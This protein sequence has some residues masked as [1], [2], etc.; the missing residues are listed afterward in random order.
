MFPFVHKTQSI[1]SLAPDSPRLAS[2]NDSIALPLWNKYIDGVDLGSGI[3]ISTYL[4]D[5]G[6]WSACQESRLVIQE[7]CQRSPW[8]QLCSW[9]GYYIAGGAPLYITLSCHNDLV[10]LQLDSLEFEKW[11]D[12]TLGHLEAFSN[13]GIE[14]SPEWGMSLCEEDNG[15]EKADAFDKIWRFGETLDV[16]TRVWVIDHNLR[17]KVDAPPCD[18]KRDRAL[19]TMGDAYFYGTDRKFTSTGLEKGGERLAHW[20]YI[21]PV[22][23]GDYRKSSLHF[24][25]RLHELYQERLVRKRGYAPKLGLLGWDRL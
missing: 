7:H 1:S 2:P 19:W 25:D 11:N 24:A 16:L 17:R 22:A 5:A 20:E 14:Y 3:N 10:I 12:G 15:G 23:G 6:L 21:N 18:E 4:I 9:S 13:V 8:P